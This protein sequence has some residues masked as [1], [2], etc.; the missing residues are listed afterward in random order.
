MRKYVGKYHGR[1][2]TPCGEFL[3]EDADGNPVPLIIW[4]VP[5]E[6]MREDDSGEEHNLAIQTNYFLFIETRDLEIGNQYSIRLPD[7]NFESTEDERFR[8]LWKT[9]NGYSIALGSA[10]PND[11]EKHRQVFAKMEAEG[12]SLYRDTRE[13]DESQF[14][15]YDVEYLD[16]MSGFAF[17]LINN[18]VPQIIFSL[19]WIESEPDQQESYE[20]AVIVAVDH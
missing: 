9:I 13:Y 7:A 1:L 12:K 2:T 16:D 19:A 20:D 8:V 3:I 10:L 17:H 18:T 15:Q 4:Q 5:R 14:T 6:L 11:D